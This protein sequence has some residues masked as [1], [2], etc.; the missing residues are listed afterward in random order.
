[1]IMVLSSAAAP[2]L[3]TWAPAWTGLSFVTGDRSGAGPETSWK[4]S[5]MPLEIS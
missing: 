2:N 1:M 5:T 3:G 4:K